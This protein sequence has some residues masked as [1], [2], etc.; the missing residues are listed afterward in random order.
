MRYPSCLPDR[1][2]LSLTPA[3][4]DDWPEFRGPTGQGHATAACRP[5]GG[6]TRTSPGNRTIPGEGWSSP[7]VC[8]G[9]RLPD[10]RRAARSRRLRRCA[11]LCLDARDGKIVWD[12][13]ALRE[14][15]ARAAAAVEEQP[16]QPDTPRGRQ[17][18]APLRPFR[19]RG[20]GLPR[21]RRQGAVAA[22]RSCAIRRSTATA[23]RR[24]WSTTCSSSAST[25][26]TSSASS[27]WTRPT[28]R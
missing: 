7:V 9:P 6:R 8:D 15:A 14:G 24:S 5:S 10:R 3:R 16:R 19:P 1:P 23:A 26:P 18:E 25:A 28:A 4:A 12:T 2:T 11:A 27:R 21:P 17:G 20:D 22:D 13:E